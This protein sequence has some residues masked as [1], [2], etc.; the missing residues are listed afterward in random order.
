MFKNYVPSYTT[1][2]F[3]SDSMHWCLLRQSSI[4]IWSWY[5]VFQTITISNILTVPSIPPAVHNG[6]EHWPSDSAPV[7]LAVHTGNDQNLLCGTGAACRY[8]THQPPMLEKET[9][10]RTW[11]PTPDWQSQ[12]FKKTW[13]HLHFYFRSWA[14]GLHLFWKKKLILYAQKLLFLWNKLLLRCSLLSAVCCRYY[15]V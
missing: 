10:S 9:V 11:I 15:L 1:W 13:L 14:K 8:G 3:H 6:T 7:P 12:S 4:S 2:S 5:P